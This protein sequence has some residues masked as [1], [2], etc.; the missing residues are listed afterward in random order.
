MKETQGEE[1]LKNVAMSVVMV[2]DELEGSE[3]L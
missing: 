1:H 3:V 2:A